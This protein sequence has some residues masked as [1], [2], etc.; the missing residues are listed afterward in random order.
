[1]TSLRNYLEVWEKYC[2][3]LGYELRYSSLEINVVQ[4]FLHLSLIL[5]N[6]DQKYITHPYGGATAVVIEKRISFLNYTTLIE[7][8]IPCSLDKVPM[9]SLLPD[10]LHIDM[11]NELP[12]V[13]ALKFFHT[14]L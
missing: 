8:S 14:Y 10:F 11:N 12:E 1:M 6:S 5:N 9:N 2:G 3:S 13:E 4:V 7:G